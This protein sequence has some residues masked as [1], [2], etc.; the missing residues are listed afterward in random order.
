M[1]IDLLIAAAGRLGRGVAFSCGYFSLPF[2]RRYQVAYRRMARRAVCDAFTAAP[3]SAIQRR[4]SEVVSG[5]TTTRPAHTLP[6]SATAMRHTP[7]WKFYR[8]A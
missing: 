2:T 7:V 1:A 4:E 6:G 5:T 3:G 8:Q